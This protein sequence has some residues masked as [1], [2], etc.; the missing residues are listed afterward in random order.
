MNAHDVRLQL[1]R[2]HGVTVVGA[3]PPSCPP[4]PSS[5]N[6]TWQAINLLIGIVGVANFVRGLRK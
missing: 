4:C 2:P 3:A 1:N 6:T 5:A